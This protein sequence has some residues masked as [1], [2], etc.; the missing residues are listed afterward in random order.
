M[1]KTDLLKELQT[2]EATKTSAWRK[3]VLSYAID[4]VA[5]LDDSVDELDWYTS[6]KIFL[7]GARDWHEYSWGGCAL[8]YDADIA[9]TL[10]TPS[11]LKKYAYGDRHPK[12]KEWLDVQAHALKCAY[13][14]IRDIIRNHDKQ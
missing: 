4:M 13:A 9:E 14:L 10:C 5:D 6:K 2:L 1:K 11:E 7:N 12:D 3:G 8:I